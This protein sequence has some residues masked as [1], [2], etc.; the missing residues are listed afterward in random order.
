[1]KSFS[2]LKSILITIVFTLITTF[3][4]FLVL[5]F[6]ISFLTPAG[7]QD[8]LQSLLENKEYLTIFF[9]TITYMTIVV[10][11]EELV[12]RILPYKLWKAKLQKIPYWVYGTI[13]AVIFSVAHSYGGTMLVLGFPQL[14][15]GFYMWYYIKFENG[16]K[17]CILNHLLY[18]S[19]TIVIVAVLTA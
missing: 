13:T 7:R 18:N 12:F 4:S 11:L 19:L 6:E 16:A 2:Y 14:L 15:L 10:S 17:L 3:L 1:M 9:T 5:Y 8:G